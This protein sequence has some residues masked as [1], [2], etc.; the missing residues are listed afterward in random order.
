MA[1]FK[2]DVIAKPNGFVVAISGR[3]GGPECEA[4]E[5]QFNKLVGLKPSLIVLD[6]NGLEYI[7]S[8]GLSALIRLHRNMKETGGK[9]RMAAVPPVVLTLLQ[10]AKLDNLIPIFMSTDQALA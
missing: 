8:M 5:E 10:A 1:A 7:S 6:M 9:V 3:A 4:L 2:V